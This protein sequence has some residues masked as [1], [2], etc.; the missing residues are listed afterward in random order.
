MS[1]DVINGQTY[2]YYDNKKTEIRKQIIEYELTIL[3]NNFDL[4]TYDVTRFIKINNKFFQFNHPNNHPNFLLGLP[5]Q[6]FQYYYS[7]PFTH[8]K[9]T[10]NNYYELLSNNDLNNSQRKQY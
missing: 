1:K 5:N 4:V 2:F 9:L 3:L 6:Y 7:F 8:V 10:N